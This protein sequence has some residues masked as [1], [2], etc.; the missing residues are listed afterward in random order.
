MCLTGLAL[1]GVSASV[2]AADPGPYT[3]NPLVIREMSESDVYGEAMTKGQSEG[4][5]I[6][7]TAKQMKTALRAETPIRI[8]VQK[9]DLTKTGCQI[10]YTSMAVTGVVAPKMGVPIGDY[11]F[12][13][14]MTLCTDQQKPTVEVIHCKFGKFGCMPGDKPPGESL[15]IK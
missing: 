2:M 7:E 14:K 4:V 1:V 9:G 15:S 3:P 8:K 10:M 13:N 12:T 6:G 11:I 5:L